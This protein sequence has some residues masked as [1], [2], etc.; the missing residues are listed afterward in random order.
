MSGFT[1]FFGACALEENK[2]MSH[3]VVLCRKPRQAGSLSDIA[4]RAFPS[5]RASQ[6]GPAELLGRFP[7][8]PPALASLLQSAFLASAPGKGGRRSQERTKW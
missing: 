3:W 4:P 1:I 5:F 6:H 7:G 8:A 2:S